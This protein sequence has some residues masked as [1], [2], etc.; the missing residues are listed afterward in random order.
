[1]VLSAI[2]LVAVAT[3]VA[4]VDRLVVPLATVL[5]YALVGAGLVATSALVQRSRRV[6][7]VWIPFVFL[8]LCYRALRGVLLLIPDEAGRHAQLKAADEAL[9][10]VSPAWW[11]EPFATSWLTELL[12]YAY[13]TMFVLPLV[14][15]VTLSVRGHERELRRA[16]LALLLAFYLGFVVFLLVPAKSPDIVYTFETPLH[17]HGFYE[18]SMTTWRRLQQITFDAFPS[19]HTAI[20]TIA[21][22]H[23]YRLGPRLAPRH[24]RAFVAAYLPIVALLQLATLYLRQ[25][26]FVDLLAAWALAAVSLWLARRA[27]VVWS[28]L[29]ATDL[30]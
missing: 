12:A 10:G 28:R 5:P 25:H 19:M 8:Y 14:V 29:A 22:V 4:R 7:R 18:A 9:L 27:E 1:G 3:L 24:P 23:A 15:L 20:S 6:V 2:A 11:M 30:A 17:G 26:Y 13:A 21:L 16:A